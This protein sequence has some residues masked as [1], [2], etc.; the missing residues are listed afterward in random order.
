M[1]N[2]SSNNEVQ[3]TSSKSER[4]KSDEVTDG[5]KTKVLGEPNNVEVN[6]EKKIDDVKEISQDQENNRF[7]HLVFDCA[8]EAAQWLHMSDFF[9]LANFSSVA[10]IAMYVCLSYFTIVSME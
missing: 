7:V 4:A 2:C 9:I 10:A 8:F 1:G 5:Q 6:E 3:S